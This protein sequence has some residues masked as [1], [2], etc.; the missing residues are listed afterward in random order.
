MGKLNIAHHKSYHPYRLDNIERVRRDEAA[1]NK[2]KTEDQDRALVAVRFLF[3]HLHLLYN[4]R[5]QDAESRLD[6]LRTR[7]G[8]T[9]PHT[10]PPDNGD[11]DDGGRTLPNTSRSITLSNGHINLF[12]DLEEHANALA[13]RASKSKPPMTDSDHGVPLAPTKQ[14]LSPWYSV[15][16]RGG[17]KDDQTSEARR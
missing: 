14:D 5:Q 16:H 1:A 4:P 17:G 9:P 2:K 3:L 15:S 10:P 7:A 8:I 13:A 6:T 11:G 12:A